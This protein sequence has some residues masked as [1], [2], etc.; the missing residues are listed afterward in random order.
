MEL[1]PLT[2]DEIQRLLYPQRR[3]VG[4]GSFIATI[5]IPDGSEKDHEITA[6]TYD[7][8]RLIADRIAKT[9]SLRSLADQ[10]RRDTALALA[11]TAVQLGTK[12]PFRAWFPLAPWRSSEGDS[13]PGSST[14]S[15]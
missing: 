3:T 5:R 4:P 9:C 15:N 10:A 14:T 11:R 13:A 7:G 12:I 2:D 8:G 6:G 1:A